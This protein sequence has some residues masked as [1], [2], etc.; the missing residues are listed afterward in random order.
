[1]LKE[2]L[3]LETLRQKIERAE[4]DAGS[5]SDYIDYGRPNE[6]D[7]KAAKENIAKKMK[8]AETLKVELHA[9]IES[10]SQGALEEWVK[11]HTNILQGILLEQATNTRDKTRLFTAR[12]TVAEWEKVLTRDQDYVGINWYYLKDYKAKAEKEFKGNWWK[13]W[14]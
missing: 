6:K 11:W 5:S 12:N 13:F 2:T 10:S 8:E 1:M 3:A 7:A 9:L 4:N 14:K